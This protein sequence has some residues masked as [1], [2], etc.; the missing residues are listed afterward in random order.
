MQVLELKVM[1]PGLNQLILY[2]LTTTSITRLSTDRNQ[3]IIGLLASI[4]STYWYTNIHPQLKYR[5]LLLYYIL[6]IFHE[7]VTS[8]YHH[9]FE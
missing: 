2:E 5:I 3:I 7:N 1:D 9:S 6:Y 8:I 4:Y